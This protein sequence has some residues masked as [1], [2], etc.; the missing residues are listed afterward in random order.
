[1]NKNKRGFAVLALCM[2]GGILALEITTSGFNLNNNFI[3]NADLPEG[4]SSVSFTLPGNNSVT[5]NQNGT[6]PTATYNLD[7]DTV[8]GNNGLITGYSGIDKVYPGN[9]TGGYGTSTT[10]LKFGSSSAV[11]TMT[12]AAKYS[13]HKVVI[14]YAT[15]SATKNSQLKVNGVMGQKVAR[16]TFADETFDLSTPSTTVTIETTFPTS[17]D[18][19][20]G[21]VRIDLYHRCGA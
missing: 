3:V 1:M 17:G 6:H 7:D 4:L 2:L 8:V 15:W 19:R 5:Y 20:V 11:G 21:I 12:I 14:N 9:S 16:L 18:R 10:T 13:V